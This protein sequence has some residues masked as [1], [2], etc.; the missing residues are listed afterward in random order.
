[1][2]FVTMPPQLRTLQSALGGMVLPLGILMLVA[3]MVLPLPIMLLDIF[4]TFNIL[5]SLLILMIALH[6]YRPLDFS[7]FPSLAFGGDGFAIGVECG[8]DA[9]RS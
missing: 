2:S 3:M 7:S 8:I 1:M 5:I 9:H 6:T 4:F